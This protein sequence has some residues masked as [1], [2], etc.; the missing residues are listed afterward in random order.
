MKK[1]AL[2][3]GAV[4]AA[5]FLHGSLETFLARLY[6]LGGTAPA[7]DLLAA[8]FSRCLC[9]T[10]FLALL[11]AAVVAV[12][13]A[14]AA[15]RRAKRPAPARAAAAA[16]FGTAVGANA[17]WFVLAALNLQTFVAWGRKFHVWEPAGFFGFFFGPGVVLIVALS[18]LLYKAF[19]KLRAPGRVIGGAAV[20]ALAGWA[21]L[22]GGSALREAR[23][24]APAADYPDVVLITLD[25]WRADAWGPSASGSS[26]TPHLDRWAEGALVFSHARSQSSWTMPAFASLFTSQYPLVHA[27]TFRR[28]LGTSQPTLAELLAANGYDTR[29]VVANELCLPATGLARGFREYRYWNWHPVLQA[30]GYYE[31]N[32]YYP[33]LRPNRKEKLDSRVTTVL[34]DIALAQLERRR[35]RPFFLWLHYLDPHGPYWPPP[36]YVDDPEIL[37]PFTGNELSRDQRGAI[38]HKRYKAEVKYVDAEVGRLLKAL[39]RSPHTVVIVTSDHGEEFLEHGGLDHGHTSYEEL[40]RVPLLMKFPGRSPAVIETP[41]DTLDLAPTLL[42]Y[43]GFEAPASMQGRSLWPLLNG[44]GTER[45][46]FAGP[47]QLK[48]KRKESVYYRGKKFLY[49]YEYPDCGAWY[50]LSSD[51]SET[52]PRSPAEAEGQQ[53]WDLLVAWREGNVEL[54]RHYRA[55]A[56]EAALRDAMKAMG[57]VK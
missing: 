33:S 11:G 30:L 49:D 24:P 22:G 44:A 21:V 37:V 31:T 40:L 18:F 25:A 15:L 26:L 10:A 19:G 4:L 6:R 56:E 5:G 20:V 41:V 45:P 57:Y 55:A 35:G 1:W 47:I 16:I 28:P 50:D 9:Y 46:S 2:Y 12:T 32:L 51:P 34:T 13:A 48:G 23:R 17:F 8:L 29:A 3:P 14:I 53:L 39:E 27:A 52:W 7:G 38:L 54:R 43:L 42:D 36:E